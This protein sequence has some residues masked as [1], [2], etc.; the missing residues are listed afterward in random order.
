MR[1][2][3]H[4][5]I[6]QGHL[7]LQSTMTLLHL[8]RQTFPYSF[9]SDPQ[10][11]SSVLGHFSQSARQEFIFQHEICIEYLYKATPQHD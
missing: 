11:G 9:P 1:R 5:R 2:H 3:F 10:T 8:A 6:L 7:P 4:L